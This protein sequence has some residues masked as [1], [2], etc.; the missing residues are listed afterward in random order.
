MKKPGEP[1]CLLDIETLLIEAAKISNHRQFVIVGS[2]S[3]LGA[4]MVPPEGMVLSR[5]VDLFP[6]LDPE[7]G[8]LEIAQ[9]LGEG[10]AFSREH[11]FFADPVSPRILSAPRNWTDRL[12]SISLSG[13]VVALFM[14]VNDAACAKLMRGNDN[15]LRWVHEGL[16]AGALS[17][18]VIRQRMTT[19]EPSLEREI[20]AATVRLSDVEAQIE[21][22]G[23][24]LRRVQRG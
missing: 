23:D 6:K 11:G 12:V 22:G 4:L 20:G 9:M 8:F 16:L 3:G 19:V 10:S 17:A 14:D 13:G 21:T 5:D 15:D 24:Q 1:M 2:L 7:R 18:Q